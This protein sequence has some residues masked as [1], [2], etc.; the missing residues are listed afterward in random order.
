M[1]KRIKCY[2][3]KYGNRFAIVDNNQYDLISKYRWNI[4]KNGYPRSRESRLKHPKRKQIQVRMHQL[5]LPKKEGYVIDHINGN[6]YDNR[7]K[8]LR[9]ATNSQNMMN[10]KTN[11][12]SN[13]LGIKG[14][15]FKDKKYEV[16]IWVNKKSI[17]LGRYSSLSDAKNCYNEHALKYF[18]KYARI[19][20]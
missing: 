18:G 19:N 20:K 13:K 9:Y 10:S 14:V 1:A 3:K 15:R 12:N 5:I 2:S 7:L 6:I 4:D 17:Y 8:N 16:H 11:W